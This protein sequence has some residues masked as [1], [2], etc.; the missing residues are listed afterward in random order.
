MVLEKDN[1][2]TKDYVGKDDKW[3]IGDVKVDKIVYSFHKD[4]FFG[5]RILYHSI[6]NFME[7]KHA[8]CQLYGEGAKDTFKDRYF[9]RESTVTICLDFRQKLIRGMS[10]YIYK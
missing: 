5:V 10:S 9:W 3:M 2:I 1:G 7:L 8:F 4:R 6:P